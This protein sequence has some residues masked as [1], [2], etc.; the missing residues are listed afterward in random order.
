MNA[1]K[2]EF[3]SDVIW[4]ARVDF[5]DMLANM[6]NDRWEFVTWL[7]ASEEDRVLVVMRRELL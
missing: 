1:P 2:Y 3:R 7:P 4:I 5:A 6:A